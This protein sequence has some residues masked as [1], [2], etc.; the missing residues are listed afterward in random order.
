MGNLLRCLVGESIKSWDSKLPQAEFAHNHAV[1]RSSGFSPFQV[2]YGIVPRGP[3]DLSSL[4]DHSRAHGGAV[5]FVEEMAVIHA[6]TSTN[7]QSS[8]QKYKA[9]VDIHRRL[10]IFNTCNLVWAVLTKD[11]M[12]SRAYNK[13]KAKKIGPLEVLERINDNAYRL[14]LPTDITTSDVFNVKYLS[15]YIPPDPILDLGSNPS[16]LGSPDVATS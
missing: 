5:S 10:L 16:H 3:V 7:L 8:S 14:S 12:P 15:P 1:N 4:P 6:E 2:I 11:R 13:L 9:A